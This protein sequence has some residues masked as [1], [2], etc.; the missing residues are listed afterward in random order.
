LFPEHAA[1]QEI[2]Q[3]LFALAGTEEG[4]E[5][6]YDMGKKRDLAYMEKVEE[7]ED[8]P[9]GI[10]EKILNASPLKVSFGLLR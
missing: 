8:V 10:E 3:V 4:D 1:S 6:A 5:A 2:K 7:D 9:V